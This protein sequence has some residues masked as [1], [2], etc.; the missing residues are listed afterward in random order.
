MKNCHNLERTSTWK[1]IFNWSERKPWWALANKKNKFRERK[2]EERK[3]WKITN[4]Q[5][6][7]VLVVI[8]LCHQALQKTE[9]FSHLCTTNTAIWRIIFHFVVFANVYCLIRDLEG[10]CTTSQLGTCWGRHKRSW[11]F[12]LFSS[13][14]YPIH[15]KLSKKPLCNLIWKY[16]RNNLIRQHFKCA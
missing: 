2:R 9:V 5:F 7:T 12:S 1:L 11:F 3:V 13:G 15:A 6:H 10:T 8:A 14:D 16:L 4:E